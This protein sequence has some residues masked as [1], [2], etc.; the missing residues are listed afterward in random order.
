MPKDS[1]QKPSLVCLPSTFW[2]LY[3]SIVPSKRFQYST[4]Y[5][6]ASLGEFAQKK[7]SL[8]MVRPPFIAS[9]TSKRRRVLG[10]TSMTPALRAREGRGCR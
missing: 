8:L 10:S 1:W 6:F 3:G 5:A 7:A 4:A 9:V 2:L